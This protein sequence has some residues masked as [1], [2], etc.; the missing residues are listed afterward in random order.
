MV[1]CRDLIIPF[2]I[3]ILSISLS[4]PCDAK[5][6]PDFAILSKIKGK[7][8][9][10]SLKKMKEGTNGMLLRKRNKIKTEKDGKAT[11][12]IK[13]GSEIRI[14]NNSELI[15][16]AKKSH[17]SR[18][19]RYRIVLLSGSLWGNFVN[20]KKPIEISD[21]TLRLQFSEASIRF[22]K[23]KTG[24]NISVLKGFV[25]VFNQSSFVKLNGGQRLYQIKKNDF[26]PQK[27]SLIP[28]QLKLSLG[29]SN[30]VFQRNK[31]IVLNLNLQVVRYG[32]DRNVERPGPVHLRSNY[33]NLELPD[34]INLNSDGNA[35]AKIKFYPPNSEDRTFGGSITF[36][37]IMDHKGFDDVRDGTVRMRF[38][39]Q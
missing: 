1:P 39:N 18:W 21:G 17:N 13:D 11:L 15:L 5:S 9:A 27:I 22:S 31:T 19:M 38:R 28:N 24:T 3:I 7:I 23:N 36:H 10:G 37:A 34:S 14:F 26:M 29:T 20:E 4:I 33:Y 6:L 12:F 32:S 35:K 25:R 2:T 8:M 30:S 16:G